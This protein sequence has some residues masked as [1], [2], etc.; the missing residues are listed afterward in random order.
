MATTGENRGRKSD[1]AVSD[2]SKRRQKRARG[3][4]AGEGIAIWF[5]YE[6]MHGK[7]RENLFRDP[8]SEETGVLI[9]SPTLGG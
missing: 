4:G 2:F 6:F 9:S 1:I 5:Q 3:A 8:Q 7:T